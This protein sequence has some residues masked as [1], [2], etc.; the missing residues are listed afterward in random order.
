[1]VIVVCIVVAMRISVSGDGRWTAGQRL[2][3]SIRLENSRHL[4]PSIHGR[5]FRHCKAKSDKFGDADMQR[6]GLSLNSRL[7][8]GFSLE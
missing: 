4:A 2:D 6:V 5:I 1:M 8:G 7:D 3:R